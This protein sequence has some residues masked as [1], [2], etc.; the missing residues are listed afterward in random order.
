[1]RKIHKLSL[2][3]IIAISLQSCTSTQKI[4]SMMNMNKNSLS[5]LKDSKIAEYKSDKKILIDSIYFKSNLL[6]EITTVT[7]TKGWFIPLVFVYVWKS[8]SNCVQGKQTI[9]E[10][11]PTF[12]REN[13]VDEI[14]RSGNFNVDSSNASEYK[15]ELSFEEINTDGPYV[16]NG[17]FYCVLYV[18]GFSY[19]DMAGP[20][21]SNLKISYRLKHNDEVVYSNSLTSEQIGQTIRG[22]YNSYK[23]L[24][25]D[26]SISMAEALSFNF[27][28][29]IASIVYDLNGY[30]A[31][32]Q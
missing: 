30:F 13:L 19:S 18:Y 12:L 15:L 27:K 5:Y 4:Q 3:V 25:R 24:Q 2:V 6:P 8:E 14:Q 16:S 1:M 31:N 23:G 29:V 10:H 7:K 11:I 28:N 9:Q 20:A 32:N 17:F 22:N 21:K 26:F